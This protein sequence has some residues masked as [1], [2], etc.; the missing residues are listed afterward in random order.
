MN[1][2]VKFLLKVVRARSPASGHHGPLGFLNGLLVVAVGHL[3]VLFITALV[4]ASAHARVYI[5]NRRVNS[6]TR[7]ALRHRQ[8][9]EVL[10][11]LGF[12]FFRFRWIQVLRQ[13]V[14]LDSRLVDD[15][16]LLLLNLF[17]SLPSFHFRK[18]VSIVHHRVGKL[19]LNGVHTQHLHDLLLNEWE[20][21][22]L[23]DI[24]SFFAVNI[25]EML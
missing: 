9:F 10:G 17:T 14:H 12:V 1:E 23:V 5:L 13:L 3:V 4:S 6:L 7:F 15:A 25:Q 19:L 21:A 2:L 22:D 8:V 11:H 20:R 18:H 16:R 24:W